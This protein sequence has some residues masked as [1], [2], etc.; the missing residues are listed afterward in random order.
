MGIFSKKEKWGN[1]NGNINNKKLGRY[2]NSFEKYVLMNEF[3]IRRDSFP[4]QLIRSKK[5]F[6]RSK[7]F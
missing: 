6:R 1:F 5:L 7:Y 3:E 2:K 4:N